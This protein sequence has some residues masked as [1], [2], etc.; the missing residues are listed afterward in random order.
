M[1]AVMKAMNGHYAFPPNKPMVRLIQR[2]YN[3]EDEA[4]R[5]AFLEKTGR[6]VA[7]PGTGRTQYY[8]DQPKTAVG[9]SRLGTSR[10]I[11]LGAYAFALDRLND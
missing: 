1:P 8:D 2:A 9:I 11:A 6:E 7:V 5:K 10:A 3:L 4:E